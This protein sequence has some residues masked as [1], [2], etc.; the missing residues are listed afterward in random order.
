MQA[1]SR[2]PTWLVT[3]ANGFLGANLGA[4]LEGKA[5]R[6]GLTRDG[7]RPGMFDEGLQGEFTE[8]A[9]L[10]DAVDRLR[11][12]VIINSAAMASHEECE[13]SPERAEMVNSVAAGELAEA[14]SLV[15]AK[16]VQISTDAV[17]D[18]ARGNYSETDEPKPFSTYGRTKL[19]GE[20]AVADRADA[21]ILRTNFFGWS[22]T[23]Q[24]SILEF[25]VNELS[26]GHHV[27]GF[28]DFFVTS[29][30]APSVCDAIWRLVTLGTTGVLHVTSTD[31]LSKYEFGRAVAE[32]F[33]LP[34]ELINPAASNVHP[35]RN[36]DIS[37]DV[38]RAEAL[39]GARLATQ[40]EG[41]ARAKADSG[42][43][44][45]TLAASLH[46]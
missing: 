8:H 45:S 18:G 20:R 26:Q 12:D 25:F 4:F 36:R 34:I 28:T 6:V 11:P 16:F 32:E 22:P 9:E 37:L 43:L 38:H 24:S 1:D 40:R 2:Q 39:L 29:G 17:F 7:G 5:H 14:A 23:G 21:L 13:R 41:I 30:Y 42:G 31:S 19:D 10:F 46:P 15:G 33:G 3:G 44:R 35:S 27:H